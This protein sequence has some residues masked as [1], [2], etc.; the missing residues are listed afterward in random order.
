M[1]P[2]RARKAVAAAGLVL[3]LLALAP[4]TKSEA[5]PPGLVVAEFDYRDTSGEV[6]DQRAAHAARLQAFSERLRSELAGTGKYR[7]LTP[8]CP[9]DSCSAA[10]SDPQE[11]I[12]QARRAGAR[13]VLYG[14]IQKMSTL[15]QYMKVEMIDV[16]TDQLLFQRLLTFRGDNDEAWDRASR[17]VFRDVAAVEIPR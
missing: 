9:A 6:V 11:L 4:V 1:I 5:Q 15:V 16:E 2:H 7:V 10:Q 12:A 8:A 3:G 17:F 13:L 14:G